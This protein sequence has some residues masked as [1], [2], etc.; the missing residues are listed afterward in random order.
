MYA[1]N[2]NLSIMRTLSIII[3]FFASTPSFG[4]NSMKFH[5]KLSQ[6]MLDR[7]G[8]ELRTDDVANTL[9]K[10][11]SKNLKCIVATDGKGKVTV[12]FWQIL[13]TTKAPDPFL[14]H[15]VNVNSAT[16]TTKFHLN[17]Q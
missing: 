14:N 4:Q 13:N 11:G 8:F 17:R 9:K 15:A 2:Q 6:K 3:F 16:T 7:D 1:T 5:H 10:I 12:D